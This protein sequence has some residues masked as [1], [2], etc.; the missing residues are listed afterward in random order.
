MKNKFNIYI[1]SNYYY[2]LKYSEHDVANKIVVEFID[3][4]AFVWCLTSIV[5]NSTSYVHN[6]TNL[7]SN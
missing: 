7:Y 2:I 1:K 5:N 4:V 6:N 3:L